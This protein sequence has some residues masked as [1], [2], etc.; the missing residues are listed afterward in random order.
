MIFEWKSSVE[1]VKGSIKIEIPKYA[2]RMNLLKDINLSFIQSGEVKISNDQIE[3][4]IKIKDVVQSKVS[5]VDVEIS[6]KKINSFEDLEYYAE[7]N[8][9]LNE[10]SSIIFNGA[11]LGN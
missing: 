11:K 5:S 9:I 1:G 10:L 3:T 7:F 8:V 4:M 2:E 6:K